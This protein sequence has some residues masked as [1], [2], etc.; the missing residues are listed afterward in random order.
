MRALVRERDGRY[1][2]ADDFIVDLRAIE[3]HG[4]DIANHVSETRSDSRRQRGPLKERRDGDQLESQLE[5][6]WTP[7]VT[8][9]RRSL[10]IGLS[11]RLLLVLGFAAHLARWGQREQDWHP[12]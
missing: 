5:K 9:G 7:A 11:G 10:W 12:A 3:G 8:P 4:I 1:S 2:S 6:A